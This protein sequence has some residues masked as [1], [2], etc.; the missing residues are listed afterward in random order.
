MPKSWEVEVFASG[1]SL[2]VI[3]SWGIAGIDNITE[4]AE[5]IRHCAEHLIA[6]TG[7]KETDN[8]VTHTDDEKPEG[9]KPENVGQGYVFKNH[10]INSGRR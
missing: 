10:F 1:E 3:G 7:K 6:F 5:L 8:K 2:L 4:H 9:E